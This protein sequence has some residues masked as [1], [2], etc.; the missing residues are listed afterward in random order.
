MPLMLP[1]YAQKA[2][3]MLHDAGF[4]AYAVGGCVRDSLLG[5]T[6]SD[7]DIT[8]NARPEQTVAAL[9]GIPTFETGVQHG[10]ITALI[11]HQ[12]VEITTYRIDG[13]YTDH[14]RPD[15]VTFTSSLR[16]DLARRDFTVNALAYSP[17]DG[18]LD[19]FG[20]AADL[21]EKTLRCVGDPD[22]RFREDALRVL[23]A[24]RFAA[25]L[26][27]SIASDT[28]DSIRRC[29]P[30]LSQIARERI[31][32]ELSRLL[33]GKNAEQVAAA[34]PEVISQ[35]FPLLPSCQPPLGKVAP[36]L[37]LRLTMLLLPLSPEDAARALSALRYD[38]ATVRH[39]HRL[40]S[41]RSLTVSPNRISVRRLLC[42]LGEPLFRD[43]LEIK[44]ACGE[45]TVQQS[46][47]LQKVIN[48][49]D[50]YSLPQLAVNGCDLA[51]LGLVGSQIGRALQALLDAVIE[52]RLPNRKERLLKHIQLGEF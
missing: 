25:T 34:F 40:L 19:L 22:T 29:C 46:A 27:F 43:L 35:C 1:P 8:T 5:L 32:H 49:A 26:G 41:C 48:D 3:T 13:S 39:V 37:H 15:S 36:L 51:A 28:A 17:E 47:M 14:R 18:I 4:E 21:Q 50:C 11:E 10:T 9:A 6:P 30:L 20:G 12:P 24:V 7:W 38:K 16:E 42:Q 44:S 33:C 23:R 31:S 2:L 52:D 45:Q